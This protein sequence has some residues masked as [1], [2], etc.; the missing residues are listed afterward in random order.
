MSRYCHRDWSY[1]Q[2]F[3]FL[4]TPMAFSLSTQAPPASTTSAPVLL[5]LKKTLCGHAAQ[6]DYR[7]EWK[8]QLKKNIIYQ[9][10]VSIVSPWCGIL[11]LGET[12]Q[13]LCGLV[14]VSRAFVDKVFQFWVKYTFK[15]ATGPCIPLN[16]LANVLANIK[17]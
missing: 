14:N 13:G 16:F 8:K 10:T 17:I 1:V 11:S 2:H 4:L 6:A 9:Q 3:F 7:H 12:P 5:C 15:L